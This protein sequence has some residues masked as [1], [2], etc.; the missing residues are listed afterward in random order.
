MPDLDI[1]H[2]CKRPIRPDDLSVWEPPA[3]EEEFAAPLIAKHVHAD[4][5]EQAITAINQAE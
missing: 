1:C 3:A 2:Y 4:C 5:Y